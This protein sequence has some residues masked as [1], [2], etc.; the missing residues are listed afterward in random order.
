[1]ESGPGSPSPAPPLPPSPAAPNPE[2]VKRINLEN[3]LKGGASWFFWIAALSLINSIVVHSGSTWGFF[4]GLGITQ[5]IDA[6]GMNWEGVVVTVITLG[7][8]VLVAAIFVAFGYF[9]RKRVVWMYILGMILYALDGLI[10]AVISAWLELGFHI[11]AL[12]MMYGGLY[13]HFELR[14]ME[15]A[16][17]A[18]VAEP[19]I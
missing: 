16:T 14:K 18:A 1:M 9:G 13:A 10:F 3:Q 2:I 11:F 12:L 4:A 8:N 19:R 7:L 6:L 15:T 5:V 17:P